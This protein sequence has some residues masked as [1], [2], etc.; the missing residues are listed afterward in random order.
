M[1]GKISVGEQFLRS[2]SMS[3]GD[4]GFGKIDPHTGKPIDTIPKYFTTELQEE[5]SEDLFKNM[6]LYNEMAIKF[7]Y[8]SEIEDQALALIDLERNK[9]TIATSVFSRTKYTKEG[10]VEISPDNSKNTELIESMVKGIIYGQKYLQNDNFDQALATF[11]KLG[12]K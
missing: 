10:G 6:A 8:L 5:A 2:I 4:V 9:G 12:E 11:R 1:G 7:K 3:E